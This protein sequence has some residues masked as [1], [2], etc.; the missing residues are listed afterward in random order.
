MAATSAAMTM[1]NRRSDSPR[2]LRHGRTCSGHPRLS[3][4]TG[5]KQA[6]MAATSAAMTT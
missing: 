2:V 6:W 5:R 1:W 4:L 3:L